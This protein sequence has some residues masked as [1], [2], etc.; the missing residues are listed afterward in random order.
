MI[1]NIIFDIG[2]VLLTFEPKKFLLQF[3]SDMA[4]I[5]KFISNIPDSKIWL[6]L[7]RGLILIE[8]A[9]NLFLIKYPK[10]K[11]LITLF[12]EKWFEIFKPIQQNIEI[13][14]KLKQ[15]G[16]KVFALSNFIKESYEF[17]INKFKFF[18][19][20]DGQVISWKEKLIKPELEIY[21]ILLNRYKLIAQ[22]CVFLDDYSDFLVSAQNLGMHT[23]LITKNIDLQTE[24]RN[25]NINI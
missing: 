21:E 6:K 8:D 17:V 20:F 2:N 9:K 16:Y 3:T 25:L 14:N 13:L 23:I 1:K 10:E 18:S 24:L 12:F 15:N 19:L 7:D 5:N 4:R 22:E 11:E